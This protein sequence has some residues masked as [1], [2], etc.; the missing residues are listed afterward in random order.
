MGDQ[1]RTTFAGASVYADVVVQ[2]AAAPITGATVGPSNTTPVTGTFT[3]SGQSAAFSPLP[4]RPVK[5][6]LTGVFGGATV[7]TMR[8]VDG[9]TTWNPMTAGGL[10]YGVYTAPA[11]ETVDTEGDVGA[12]YQFAVTGATGTTNI[13]YRL[14]HS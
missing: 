6:L 9:A 7:T 8:S 3:A 1:V 4:G 13:A 10:P 12:M 14:G 11:Q 2:A 5:I